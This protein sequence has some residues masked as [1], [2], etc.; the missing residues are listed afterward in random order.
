MV[1]QNCS[2][3]L[4]MATLS[5]A[6]NETKGDISCGRDALRILLSNNFQEA[7]LCENLPRGNL[8]RLLSAD[9]ILTSNWFRNIEDVPLLLTIAFQI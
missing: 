1:L 3:H 5:R 2:L 7:C 4:C 9:V 8:C 6:S